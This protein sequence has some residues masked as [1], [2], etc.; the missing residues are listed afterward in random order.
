MATYTDE[1][2]L[3]TFSNQIGDIARANRFIATFTGS[4]AGT[5]PANHR[6]FVKSS[7]LPGRTLGD[8]PPLQ[9]FG[10]QDK[11]AGDP[12]YEDLT[13]T[14]HNDVNFTIKK[15]IEE[16]MEKIAGG[17]TNQREPASDYMAEIKMEQVGSGSQ[18]IA[19]YLMHGCYPKA[20]TPVDVSVESADTYS[21]LSVTF[22]VNTWTG[23][24]DSQRA[25]GVY[26]A[27]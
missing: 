2:R 22:N 5:I 7:Q 17:V 23:G 13:V 20:M 16:W 12:V 10:M 27:P 4:G 21:E 1:I 3:N 11:R 26:E 9:W 24:P 15:W 6:Y 18:V 8:L 25:V 19:T 14:F